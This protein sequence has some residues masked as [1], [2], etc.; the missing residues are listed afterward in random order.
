MP[1]PDVGQYKPLRAAYVIIA[2]KIRMI[3][4]GHTADISHVLDDIEELLDASVDAIPYIIPEDAGERRIDLSQLDFDALRERFRQGRK[5][6]EVEKLK[7]QVRRKVDQMVALNPTRADY[8]EK[9]QQLIDAY[10]AGS[11]NVDEIFDELLAFVQEIADED[12]RHLREGLS[13][14]ELALF[15][16]LTKGEPGDLS[17][18]DIRKVKAGVR[19]LLDAIEGK[20]GIDWRERQQSRADVEHTIQVVLDH[21]LPDAYD[22]DLYE[23]K[24]QRVFNHVVENYYGG[25]R[26]VYTEAA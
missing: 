23:E 14:E 5:R 22:A 3:Q 20:L 9:L 15:D 12:E 17:E 1:H 11:R 13:E 16:I 25:G 4:G 6:T 19:A 24:S 26:S 10:N 7:A 8:R 18:A 21:H 2:R